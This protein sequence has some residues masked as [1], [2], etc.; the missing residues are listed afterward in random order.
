MFAAVMREIGEDVSHSELVR[1]RRHVL[2]VYDLQLNKVAT[3]DDP[4]PEVILPRQIA[5]Y[6]HA[7]LKA[8]QSVDDVLVIAPGELLEMVR[9]SYS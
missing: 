8:G 4:L 9:A 6:I 1:I 3:R 7:R 5:G 2:D